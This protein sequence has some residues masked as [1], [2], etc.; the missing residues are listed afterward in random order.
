MHR[1]ALHRLELTWSLSE[2]TICVKACQFL[3]CK[4]KTTEPT[5][6]APKAVCPGV[7]TALNPKPRGAQ[8][9]SNPTAPAGAVL[10]PVLVRAF[11]CL[12]MLHDRE[13]ELKVI[14][15]HTSLGSIQHQWLWL[16]PNPGMP[17][18]TSATRRTIHCFL[19]AQ[20]CQLCS[21]HSS[22]SQLGISR[23][24]S[25][26]HILSYNSAAQIFLTNLVTNLTL[27]QKGTF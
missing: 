2:G 15:S 11:P 12:L 5:H 17:S 25:F 3:G 7:L 18:Q 22:T 20:K 26:F 23:I 27:N 8:Q 6:G 14:S 24:N 19:Q 4:S 16:I 1:I 21:P 10:P 13:R 9:Q